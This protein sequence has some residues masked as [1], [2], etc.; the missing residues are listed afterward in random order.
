MKYYQLEPEVAGG[1]GRNTVADTSLHPP[2]VNQLHY[3][4]SGWLGD[5]IVESF[6]CFIATAE[7]AQ[8]I[9]AAGLTGCEITDV[10]VS[11][12]GQ[13]EGMNPGRK[14]PLSQVFF[15]ERNKMKY[16]GGSS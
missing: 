1:W 2:V 5:C 15:N 14:L 11:V 4:F 12:S 6:P 8:Q 10:E 7:V 9:L 3:E 13:F 16:T